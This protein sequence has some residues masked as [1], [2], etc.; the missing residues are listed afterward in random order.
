MKWGEYS[1]DVQFILQRS[2]QPKSANSSEATK[3]P[4]SSP[5][6]SESPKKAKSSLDHSMTNEKL[7]ASSL[8][9]QNSIQSVDSD[10]VKNEPRRTDLIGIVRGKNFHFKTTLN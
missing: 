10:G 3:N 9:G 1:S 2:D 5:Q 4:A 7:P 6:A 8:S